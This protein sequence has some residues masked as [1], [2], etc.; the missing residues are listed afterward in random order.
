[1]KR[2]LNGGGAGDSLELLLDTLCNIFGGIVLISCLLAILPRQKMPPPL[3]P[4]ESA[5]EEMTERR[6]IKATEE[7]DRLKSD[8]EQLSQSTDPK[9]AE[10]QSRRNSLN[11]LLESLQKNAKDKDDLELNEADI[12]AIA[13][14]GDPKL[15]EEKLMEL[16]LQKSK[17]ES[18]HATT[19]D[20]IRYLE[21]RSKNLTE[22]AEKLGKEKIQA[23][24]FPRER[25]AKASPFPIIVRYDRVYPLQVDGGKRSN[26]DVEMIPIDDNSERARPIMGRGIASPIDDAALLTLLKVVET[27]GYYATVYLYPDSHRVFNDLTQVMGKAGISYGLEFVEAARE[28]NFGSNGSAPPEL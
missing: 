12:R 20:K 7:I 21:Q 10:L 9:I 8:I 14:K 17:N 23:V 18:K 24:R 3:I 13:A 1:M 16:K 27:K 28:L 6:I 2:R 25:A 15:L 26:P 19:V 5:K 4:A 22:E 11:E